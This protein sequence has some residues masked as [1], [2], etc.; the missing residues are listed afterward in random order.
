MKVIMPKA[1]PFWSEILN[2]CDS[3]DDFL[4]TRGLK[5]SLVPTKPYQ[6]TKRWKR[7]VK[8]KYNIT[9]DFYALKHLFLD[10][11]DKA[12][13]PVM[14]LSKGMASHQTNVTEKVYL[15]GREKRKNEVLKNI[16]LKVLNY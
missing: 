15:V 10:E 1:I 8:D 6:I 9:A 2:E 14:N 4:F 3:D 7:L 16:Q 13:N 11:L 5:P 12:S